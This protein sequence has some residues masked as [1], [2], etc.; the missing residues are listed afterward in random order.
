MYIKHISALN[1]LPK[2]KVLI[3]R[4]V[5]Y[6][7]T[8]KFANNHPD[9]YLQYQQ[10]V[11]ELPKNDCS[12]YSLQLF[13]HSQFYFPKEEILLCTLHRC[14]YV[15]FHNCYSSCKTSSMCHHTEK[16]YIKFTTFVRKVQLNVVDSP[17][18]GFD[19][20]N[21]KLILLSNR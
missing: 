9:S 3:R 18:K 11:L 7:K 12:E 5:N 4:T 8:N 1:N 20:V 16:N 17:C 15:L 2:G 6:N 21:T 10:W 13:P 19:M 14:H